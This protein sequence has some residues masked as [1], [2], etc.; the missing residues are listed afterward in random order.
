MNHYVIFT[1]AAWRGLAKTVSTAKDHPGRTA[2]RWSIYIVMPELA[3]YAW[4]VW[5]DDDDELFQQPAYLRDLFWNYKVADDLWIRIPKPWELGAMAAGVSRAI[6]HFR[7]NKKAF[8]GWLPS[9]DP[10]HKDV[11]SL[12]KSFAPV[13]ETA[14]IGPFR[15]LVEVMANYDFFRNRNIVSPWEWGKRVDL[16]KGTGRASR[17]GQLLQKAIGVDGRSMDHLI[18]SQFG[19][20]GRLGKRVSDLGREDR[21][22]SIGRELVGI[23]ARSPAYAARD[24]QWVLN[25]AK[26]IGASTH[27][28]VRKLNDLLSANFQSKT[29]KGKDVQAAR[30]RRYATA[31]RAK[32]EKGTKKLGADPV[33]VEKF[34]RRF[35]PR[36][37]FENTKSGSISEKRA[38][39]KASQ[40]EAV[41]WFTEQGLKPTDLERAYMREYDRGIKRGKT[42][43]G[44][45]RQRKERAAHRR[46]FRLNARKIGK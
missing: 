6:H 27:G 30:A 2:A 43:A 11:G 10:G 24:V 34:S 22:A 1:S 9:F 37:D 28:D 35:K 15:G 45:R 19:G 33:L 42:T 7:G 36:P 4:N 46:A 21:P 17:V 18:E 20:L 38:A 13:D 25:W 39:W 31:L 16:R 44:R 29:A 26:S 3:N 12:A 40:K 14:L 32:I 5:H 23:T 8:E 41:D